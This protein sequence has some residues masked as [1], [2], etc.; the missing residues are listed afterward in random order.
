MQS[1]DDTPQGIDAE[2]MSHVGKRCTT[3]RRDDDVDSLNSLYSTNPFKQVQDNEIKRHSTLRKETRSVRRSLLLALFFVYNVHLT[4]A[5]FA[6]HRHHA[7][8]SFSFTIFTCTNIRYKFM[9]PVGWPFDLPY[10]TRAIIHERQGIRCDA[11]AADHQPL[12]IIERGEH[13]AFS[14]I[15][16]TRAT[17][18]RQT[19]MRARHGR[20]IEQINTPLECLPLSDRHTNGVAIGTYAGYAVVGIAL[21]DLAARQSLNA[22]ERWQG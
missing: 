18:E 12:M 2:R 1:I 14:E 22:F 7:D 15:E 4:L 17:A 16:C 3:V 8:D 11:I 9:S 21:A 5:T 10:L 6:A 19:T 13:A 20:V